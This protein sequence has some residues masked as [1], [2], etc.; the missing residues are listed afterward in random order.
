[1]RKLNTFDNYQKDK[2]IV[3]GESYN[4]LP[5]EYTTAD[6]KVV[7]GTWD[8]QIAADCTVK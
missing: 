4:D 3:C 8:F 2:V 5:Y 1:M 6:N 7:E